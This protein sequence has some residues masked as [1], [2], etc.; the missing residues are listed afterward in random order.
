MNKY[1]MLGCKFFTVHDCS[2][3]GSHLTSPLFPSH[4]SGPSW[5]LS[6]LFTGCRFR[7]VQRFVRGFLARSNLVVLFR[8]IN[9]L[10]LRINPLYLLWWSL[11][12]DTDTLPTSWRA[13]LIWPV[14]VKGFVFF[15]HPPQLFSVVLRAF[16]SSSAPALWTSYCEVTGTETSYLLTCNCKNKGTTQLEI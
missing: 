14:A 2:R 1:C 3:S 10:H 8:L 11:L 5:S 13:I 4:H 9:N 12:F 15:Y 6:P 16:S 7:A